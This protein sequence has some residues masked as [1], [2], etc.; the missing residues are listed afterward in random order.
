MSS[1]CLQSRGKFILFYNNGEYSFNE[2]LTGK[3]STIEVSDWKDNYASSIADL[4]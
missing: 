4:W 2:N 3:S 1:V